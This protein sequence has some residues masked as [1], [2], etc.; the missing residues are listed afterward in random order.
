MSDNYKTL[1]V[2]KEAWQKAKEQKEEHNR[3]WGEQI[4]RPD[5]EENTTSESPQQ[6]KV[7]VENVTI[8]AEESGVDSN[9]VETMSTSDVENIVESWLERHAEDLRKGRI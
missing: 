8:E 9:D 1:R 7:V 2:P 6:Q 5:V 3:T 4:V